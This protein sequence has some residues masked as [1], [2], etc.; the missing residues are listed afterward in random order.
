[1][2]KLYQ[3]LQI[4]FT[5]KCYHLSQKILS[6]HYL[7]STVL[8]SLAPN[9]YLRLR[10]TLIGPFYLGLN[11]SLD[12]GWQITPVGL[13]LL[14]IPGPQHCLNLYCPIS[15]PL[16]TCDNW[17][18]KMWLVQMKMRWKYKIRHV[19]WRLGT[20]NNAKHHNN[21]WYMDYMLKY[22]GAARLKIIFTCFFYSLKAGYSKFKIMYVV[23]I[24]F[25][26]VWILRTSS[27]D[28]HELFM[29]IITKSGQSL[30]ISLLWQPPSSYY[31]CLANYLPYYLKRYPL[32]WGY[33]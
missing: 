13:A 32:L 24:M 7:Q 18:L 9:L 11:S 27:T 6:T 30:F 16:A 29:A 15:H 5:Q 22:L 10:A 28:H 31:F 21:L 23:H 25:L 26:L 1:M 14:S 3:S 12:L 19:Y 17:S 8:Q 33:G 4:S 20:Q 2:T